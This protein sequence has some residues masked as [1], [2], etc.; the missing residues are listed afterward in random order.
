MSSHFEERVHGGFRGQGASFVDLSTNLNPYGPCESVLSAARGAALDRYP[1]AS[2]GAARHAWA[3]RLSLSADELSVGHGAADLFW[4]IARARLRPG[5]RVV[6]A[7]PTFSEME[8]AA[9]AAGAR[10]ER[11]TLFDRADQTSSLDRLAEVARDA[12]LVYLCS[13]NNPTG[14]YLTPVQLSAL[15]QQLPSAWLVIDQSFLALSEHAS[16]LSVRFASNV[17]CVRSLTKDFALAGLRIGYL[18]ADPE[19]VAQIERAR[20]T[21]STSEPALRAIE[22]AASERDFVAHSYTRLAQDRGFLE[23]GLRALGLM[24]WPSTTVFVLVPVQDAARTTALLKTRGVGVRDAS[25]FGLSQH[26]RVAV[27]PRGQTERLLDALR[28]VRSVGGTPHAAM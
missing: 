17:I 14:H 26:V 19:V 13:P 22:A 20:P 6:I 3:Q 1:D 2:S 5:D 21:W 11:V 15:A 28:S 27:R 4:A 16:D 8:F 10:V 18:V 23:R 12:R 24:S 25:S 9:R 7:G